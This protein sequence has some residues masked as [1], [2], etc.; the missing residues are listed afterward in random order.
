MLV[1]LYCGYGIL[2]MKTVLVFGTFDVIH[3]GHQWFLRN[4]ARHGDRLVAVVSRD[5]FV[6][7]WKGATP[8]KNEKARIEALESSELVDQAVLADSEI[9]TY[10]VVRDIKPNIICLGHDQGALKDDLKAWIDRNGGSPPFI[11]ILPPWRRKIFSSSR[12]NRVLQGAGGDTVSTTWIL[13]ILMVVAM[14]IVGFT[15]VSGKR[16]SS[17]APPATLAFIRFALTLFCFLPLMIGKRLPD[18][19]KSRKSAGWLWSIAAALAISAYNLLFF[20]G[21]GAGLA[22][23]GGLIV[24]TMNPLFTFLIVLLIT[25]TQPRISTVAGFSVGIIGAVLMLEPWRYTVAE[26]AD[27]GNLAYL[28]AALA[29]SLLTLISH[30]AQNIL[31]FRRFNLRLY[32]IA[33]LLMAPIAFAET[34]G[35]IPT[36]M[37]LAFWGDMIIISAA[38]GAFGTGVYFIA[39]SRL[40]AARG[41]AFTYLVPVSALTFTAIILGE[42]PEPVMIVGGLL[43]ISAFLLINRPTPGKNT[44]TQLEGGSE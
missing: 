1:F 25:R 40:G 31:G 8:V 34:G 3:P 29:W 41:S 26:L 11:H 6:R 13:S 35:Q 7:E 24:T 37:G 21:L 32:T 42:K 30:K 38:V 20:I 27:S 22:G 15:W 43:A 36:G 18:I 10:G 9:R 39:S 44:G 12:R 17:I 5:T 33:T 2:I 19:S 28:A 16:I 23:K 14:I 4:A